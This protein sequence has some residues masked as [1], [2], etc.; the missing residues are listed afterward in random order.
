MVENFTNYRYNK[1][2]M[3]KLFAAI[4]LSS[5][6]F[7]ACSF[8]RGE[9]RTYGPPK[10]PKPAP[11]IESTTEET[12]DATVETSST[13]EVETTT[14]STDP[15]YLAYS[16]DLYNSLLGK[17][18]FALFFHASWCEVC[19]RVESDITKD[20]ANFPAGTK[21]LKAN[22]DTET[23]LKKTYGITVQ[24]NIVIIDKNGNPT[25]TLPGPSNAELIEAISATL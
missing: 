10:R 12:T 5:L 17:E 25:V 1:N 21:I 11:V 6:L 23:E 8:F 14:T 2:I 3:K 18:P 16:E 20:L 9:S 7:S 24:S 4:L 15:Q 22:F 19:R 13:T